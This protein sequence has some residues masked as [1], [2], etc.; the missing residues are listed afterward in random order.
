ML[1]GHHAGSQTLQLA[2]G[3]H[4]ELSRGRPGCSGYLG[5]L[6]VSFFPG[7][8]VFIPEITG[9]Y[10]ARS[11]LLNGFANMA[12][13][14]PPGGAVHQHKTHLP[15]RKSLKVPLPLTTDND[16]IFI[17]SPRCGTCI[18]DTDFIRPTSHWGDICCSLT[19]TY[20]HEQ[21]F[22]QDVKSV[23]AIDRNSLFYHS[24]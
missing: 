12:T 6:E 4:S 17:R 23:L 11:S 14:H 5:Y 7:G 10:G 22:Q 21:T 2:E 16:L 3:T 20:L 15:Q 19:H 18:P 8:S 1:P 9:L 13:L 24:T